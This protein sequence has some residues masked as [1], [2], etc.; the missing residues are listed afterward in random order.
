MKKSKESKESKKHTLVWVGK[1]GWN[2]DAGRVQ[3]G[4]SIG[5]TEQLEKYQRLIDLNLIKLV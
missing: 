4:E 3:H 5:T 2:K 1:S